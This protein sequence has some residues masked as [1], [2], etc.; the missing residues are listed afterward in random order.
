MRKR[1]QRRSKPIFEEPKH[2]VQKTKTVKATIERDKNWWIAVSLIAIFF[3]VLLLNSYFNISSGISI[4]EEGES[5]DRYYLSGP[6]PYYNMRLIEET[7]YGEKPGLYPFYSETDPLLDYPIGE[8]GGRPPLLN[9]MAIGFSRLL[10]PFMDEIDALGYSMQFIPALFGALL[11]FPVYIIGKSLFGRKEGVLAALFI[12]IIPIHLGSGHGSAYSLFDHD[13]LNLLLFFL[14]YMF[15]LKS[16]KEIDTNKSILFALL[17]GVSLAALSMTWVEARYLYVIIAVYFII[18]ML[19]DIFKS[20]IEFGIVRSSLILL[21]SGYILSLPVVMASEKYAG[22]RPDLPFFICI[23]VL[24]FA[25]LYYLFKKLKIPWP[26]SLPAVFSIGVIGLVFLFFMDEIS[27]AYPIFSPLSKLSEILFGTGIY[28]NKVSQTIAEAGTFGI[29]RTV[30]SFGPVLYWLAWLSFIYLFYKYYRNLRRDYLFICVIFILSIGLTGVAGRF[31]NDLVPVVAI[32][33]AWIIWILVDRIDYKQMIRNIRSSGGGIHGLRRGIKFMHIFGIIFI[34]F[35]VLFPNVYLSFDA[36]I[37]A[38]EKEEIFGEN[39][40]KGAYGLQ[41][42]KETYWVHAFSWLKDQDSDIDNPVERPAFISWWDYGFYE[43]AVGEHPAVADNFQDGIPP[44]ANFHTAASEEEAVAVWIVRLLEGNINDND[45]ILS[46]DVV[47]VLEKYFGNE[48]SNITKWME[49]PKSSLSY[50]TPIGEEYDEELSTQYRVGEQWS[51]NAIYHDISNIIVE[52]LNDEKITWLYHDIQLTT[53]Y[54]IR[55]YGVEGYD[56]QIFNIFGFLADKSLILVSGGGIYNPED[57]FVEIRFVTQSGKEL[58]FEELDA[59]SDEQLRNDPPVNTKPFYKD[60]YFDTMFYRTYIGI[61]EGESG[62]KNEPDYQLPCIDMR[63]FCAEYISPS[64]PDF[65]YYPNKAAVVIAKYYAGA[66]VN[67]SVKFNE[68]PVNTQVVVQKNISHYDI[69]IP[70]DHDKNMTNVTSG[71]FSVIAPAGDIRLQVR[72]YPEL[73]AGAFIQKN[74]TFNGTKGSELAPISDDEAMRF[75]GDYN[76][77]VNITIEPASIQGYVYKDKDNDT[78]YNSSVDEPLSDVLLVILGVDKFNAENG[79]PEQ[80]DYTMYIDNLTTDKMGYYSSY[81]TLDLLPGYYRLMAY[82]DDFLIYDTI[83]PLYSGNSSYNISEPKRSSVSGS[84]YFD[85]NANNEFDNGEALNNVDIVIKYTHPF[86]GEKLIETFTTD[87]TGSYSFDSL[88]PGEYIINATKINDSTG[89]LNYWF[90]QSISLIENETTNYNIS[91]DF[92]TIELSGYTKYLDENIGNITINFLAN[93]SIENNTATPSQ[94]TKSDA[95]T[96]FYKISLIP[97][98]YNI[99]VDEMITIDNKN[100]TYS[101]KGQLEIK[102]GEGIKTYDIIM[103][104]E[105]I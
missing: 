2:V 47:E 64:L 10:T 87:A 100:I 4:N 40:P 44:A 98:F 17:G 74:V 21:F 30:M 7:M 82:T 26:L 80:Y 89:Y 92:A 99:S 51:T 25:I 60:P 12:A 96:G 54:S 49:N 85:E 71:E 28:G 78:V 15:L 61:S 14:T 86:V 83:V 55:Y 23:A 38:T 95:E 5:L 9:M 73:R 36:A 63:H 67:G 48:T 8:S 77:Y 11:V 66:Y 104:K 65:F 56:K 39:L 37:P 91:I 42:S 13:S 50:N 62:S 43:S 20:K 16:I 69:E 93:N 76:R 46:E 72:R 19:V 101:F 88:Y 6:D 27:V 18:Q 45:G 79:Q 32:L 57:E 90:E 1:A 35:L 31:I 94:L 34:A 81:K 103:I 41:H 70:I 33:S 75:G 58:T 53:G 102:T 29:S 22:F 97:G 105:E 59:L 84:V 52:R 24:S 3:M 68:K